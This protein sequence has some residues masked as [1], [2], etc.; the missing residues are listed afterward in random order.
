MISPVWYS[1]GS[2]SI[3]IDA[4]PLLQSGGH[5]LE[6]VFRESENLGPGEMLELITPFLPAPL[7]EKMGARGFEC[8]TKE[9]QG[10]FY[11]YF[12]KG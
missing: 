4:R 7:I 3:T 6:Q 5:P 2:V 11:N 1:K 12:H 9:D 10:I 8:W